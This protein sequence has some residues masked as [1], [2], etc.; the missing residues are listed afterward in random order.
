MDLFGIDLTVNEIQLLRQS[1]DVITITGKDAKF[2][3]SLQ[4]KLESELH[5]IQVM[6]TSAET[7]KQNELQALI[8]T[9]KRKTSKN[10]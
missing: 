7:Q 2:I 9:E 10:T 1:L 3:A 5:Q 6:L 4:N 8:E